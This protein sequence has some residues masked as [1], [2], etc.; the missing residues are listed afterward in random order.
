[1]VFSCL[2]DADFL[3]TERFMKGSAR[4]HLNADSLETLNERLYSG[5]VCRIGI[6]CS[7]RFL[8]HGSHRR[9]Q[10]VRLAALRFAACAL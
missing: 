2:V 5:R 3:C 4:E 9:R 8:A 7:R 1:M 6:G 10:D